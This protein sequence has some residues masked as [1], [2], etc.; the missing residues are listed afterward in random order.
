MA[1]GARARSIE[2]RMVWVIELFERLE[3]RDRECRTAAM[4][5]SS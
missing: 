3:R 1:A 5:R 2:D 4:P